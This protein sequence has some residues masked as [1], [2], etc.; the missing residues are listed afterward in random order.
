VR[1][2]ARV[3]LVVATM[4]RDEEDILEVFLRHHAELA[5]LILVTL[6]RC[7][8]RSEEITRALRREGLPIEVTHDEREAYVQSEVATAAMHRAGGDLKADWFLPLDAD[9]FLGC[10][11]NVRDVLAE[12]AGQ[13]PLSLH[14]KTYVPWNDAR[15]D[16][17]PVRRMRHRL[18]RET[19]TTPN[20]LIPRALAWRLEMRVELGHHWLTDTTTGQQVRA[21][22]EP[23]LWLAHYPVRSLPQLRR[24]VLA[25]W[26]ALRARATYE[27]GEG[28]HCRRLYE[29]FMQGPVPD[30]EL[31][32]LAASYFELEPHTLTARELVED[33][34]ALLASESRAR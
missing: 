9:E 29:R 34:F 13:Q 24:K 16:D 25:T 23:K 21:V 10:T 1:G 4:V 33:P 15:D 32:Q 2:D 20:L 31:P 3:K 7:S 12:H 6:H 27:A 11:T 22:K 28:W 8:D 18:R 5:D 14:W 19:T 26:P 30:D 17:N